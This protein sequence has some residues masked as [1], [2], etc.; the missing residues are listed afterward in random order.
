MFTPKRLISHYIIKLFRYVPLNMICLLAVVYGLPL[1]GSGPVWNNFATLVKPCQSLWW[2]NAVWISNVYPSG[3]DE[4]CLPWTWFVP[5]Y[6][7]LSLLLPIFIALFKIL[8]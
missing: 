3:F 7:Q 4:K 1:I 8:P 5:C 6:V 2:T